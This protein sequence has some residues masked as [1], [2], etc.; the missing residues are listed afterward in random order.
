[1]ESKD[2]SY[3]D[4]LGD[5]IGKDTFTSQTQPLLQE[6][7]QHKKN[8]HQIKRNLYLLLLLAFSVAILIIFFYGFSESS[9]K[10]M[11]FAFILACTPLAVYY[12]KIKNFQQNFILF[13][14]CQENNWIYNPDHDPT[15]YNQLRSKHPDFFKHGYSQQIEDQ[16]W[17]SI[18]NDKPIQ[19]WGCLFVYQTG[20]GKSTKI[21]EKSIFI[22][23][24]LKRLPFG[25]TLNKKSILS[26]FNDEYKTESEQFNR[27]FQVKVKDKQP[28]SRLLLL[29][30]LSPSVQM[31]LIQFAD[32]YPLESIGFHENIMIVAFDG[33]LWK[34]NYTNFFTEVKVDSRDKD[35]FYSLLKF[36][37]AMPTEMLKFID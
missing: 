16:I 36:M 27:L 5:K 4:P 35:Y 24:L 21:H 6:A 34:P 30:I 22:L 1:M 19:F 3:W 17:G 25:F 28:N 8:P 31:R 20:S 10:F 15:R 13:L 29:K 12:G 2:D 37:I 23:R 11:I 33:E 18:N 9:V 32:D 26:V 14:M 7:E